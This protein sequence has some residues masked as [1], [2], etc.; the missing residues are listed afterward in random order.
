MFFFSLRRTFLAPADLGGIRPVLSYGAFSTPAGYLAFFLPATVLR[1][2]LRAA[3]VCG[4]RCDSALVDSL[5]RGELGPESCPIGLARWW[6]R[7]AAR[8]RRRGVRCTA[9]GLPDLDWVRVP[10][11]TFALGDAEVPQELGISVGRQFTI[12]IP[13][14]S[15][16]TRYQVTRDQFEAF[17][18]R[19]YN[20]PAY[21]SELGHTWRGDRTEPRYWL[22]PDFGLIPN[23]PVVGVTWFEADAFAR[24]IHHKMVSD[25]GYRPSWMEGDWEVSLPLVCEWEYA[26]RFPDGRR[27]PWGNDYLAASANID[28]RFEGSVVGPYFL[29]RP[30]PVGLY[31]AGMSDLGIHD[32]CGNVWEWCASTW[33]PGYEFPE[34]TEVVSVGHRSVRGGSWY[35]SVIYGASAGHT[36]A[37]AAP[38]ACT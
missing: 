27:F 33:V 16:L 1:G 25:S 20:D 22:D 9:N 2:P 7:E 12:E 24:W 17:V 26:A 10:A 13:Y 8:D 29:Q 35:N 14:D 37:M 4:P 5:L 32:M 30:T 19:A 6:R 28:E 31:D 36:P 11:G 23:Q 38:W 18:R 34:R 15:A 21:W 3:D